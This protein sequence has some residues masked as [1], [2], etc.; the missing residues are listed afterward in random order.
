[1]GYVGY[2][3]GVC[4]QPDLS[5]PRMGK[6]TDINQPIVEAL[7]TEALVLADEVRQVFDLHPVRE[8][9]QEADDLRLALS[10][11]G[12]RTTTRVMHVLAWLLN[13]RAYFAEELTE[14]QLRRHSK[15]P[16]DRP[17]ERDNLALLQPET[18]ELIIQSE[19]LHARISRLDTA[20]RDR[21]EMRPAAILR[22]QQR[23][24]EAMYRS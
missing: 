22:L 8:T 18:C 24:G 4:P 13:H 9:G 17:A 10:V 23:L 20:W 2:P 3:A 16:P 7:Y 14:F 19:N 6:P 21:F 5:H 1:M 11:E 12:L 15:L